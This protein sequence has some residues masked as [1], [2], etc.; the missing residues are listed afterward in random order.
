MRSKLRQ[1]FFLLV[2]FCISSDLYSQPIIKDTTEAY[3]YWAKRGI[4]EMVYAYMQDYVATVDTNKISKENKGAK[5]YR[6]KFIANVDKKDYIK[7]EKDFESIIQFLTKNNWAGTA[8]KVS[9]TLIENYSQHKPIEDQFFINSSPYNNN[10]IWNEKKRD[11]LNSYG[12]EL[13]RLEKKPEKKEKA[14][15]PK[16]HIEDDNP[17]N[18]KK[19]TIGLLLIFLY[20]LGGLIVGGFS[21]YLYSKSHIYSILSGEKHKYVDD[22]R[23]SHER[24]LFKYIG[25]FA[26]LKKSKDEYKSK[27]KDEDFNTQVGQLNRQISELNAKNTKLLNENIELGEI[28]E[29]YKGKNIEPKSIQAAKANEDVLTSN[30]IY[31]TIPESDGSFRIANGKNIKEMDCFYK[32]EVDN[33]N[34][35]GKLFFISSDFDSRALDNIDYYLNPV[36][37][38]ENI[39]DR[40]QAKKINV[41]NYG[42]VVLTG[43]N[44]KIDTNNK[45][46]IRLI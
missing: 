24:Y 11:I 16:T 42:I 22:L 17:K 37:E 34:Q 19:D 2:C 46:K 13:S 32:I 45:L 25:L 39:S 21:I 26:V 12:S 9:N 1:V 10:K 7:V 28:I 35:K 4:I 8:R 44:W 38:I 6:A 31:F 20:F 41:V 27:S 3:N 5:D 30:A 43:E 23:Y 15:S 36:C 33:N 29:R 18:I 14:D 40:T